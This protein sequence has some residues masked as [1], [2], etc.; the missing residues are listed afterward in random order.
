MQR[1]DSPHGAEPSISFRT[2]KIEEHGNA[3]KG[4]IKPKIRL[5]GLWLERA[6]FKPGTRVHV[7]CVAPGLI[8]LRSPDATMLNETK[9][10]SSE[11]KHSV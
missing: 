6:G 5:L 2:L 11:P 4:R 3:W 9:H 10:G 8:E 7:R 1:T